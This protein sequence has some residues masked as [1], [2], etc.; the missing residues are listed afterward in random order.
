MGGV[1]RESEEGFGVSDSDRMEATTVLK[2]K[3]Y[4]A[5]SGGWGYSVRAIV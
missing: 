2:K 3:Y 5:A 4:K 1:K